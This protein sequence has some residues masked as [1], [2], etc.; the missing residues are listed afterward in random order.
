MRVHVR[1]HVRT[2]HARTHHALRARTMYVCAYVHHACMCIVRAFVHTH[3]A[4]VC[5]HVHTYMRMYV[6]GVCTCV[7]ALRSACVVCATCGVRIRAHT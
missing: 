6:R 5:A 7:C 3:S 2:T 4:Y 1:A